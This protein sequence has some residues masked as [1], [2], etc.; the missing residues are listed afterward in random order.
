MKN[1]LILLITLF[2]ESYVS[3]QIPEFSISDT[4]V[5]I[6]DGR[7]FDSGGEGIIYGN[8]ENE[9]GPAFVVGVKPAVQ[10]N[11][12]ENVEKDEEQEEKEELKE[13]ESPTEVES[14]A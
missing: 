13:E 10:D 9:E 14:K 3:A 1:L 4:L 2:I 8:N 6:C 12:P 7:L 11:K 5:S